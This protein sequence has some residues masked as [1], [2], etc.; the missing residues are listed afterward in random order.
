MPVAFK[1]TK[2]Y[3]NFTLLQATASWFLFLVSFSVTDLE[4]V[5]LEPRKMG[6]KKQI[7]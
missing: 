1:V 3:R 6:G 7:Q 5:T 4:D 2:E